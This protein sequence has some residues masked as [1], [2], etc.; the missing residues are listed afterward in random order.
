VRFGVK[1]AEI[2]LSVLSEQC[3]DRRIGSEEGLVAETKAWAEARNEMKA[4]AVWRFGLD[5]ARVKLAHLYPRP[6]I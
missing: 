2:E 1:K 3:L 5:E 6:P 4:K